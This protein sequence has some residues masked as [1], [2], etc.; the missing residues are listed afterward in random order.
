MEQRVRNARLVAVL[1]VLVA[2]VAYVPRLA[3]AKADHR[4]DADGYTEWTQTDALPDKAGKY[5]LAGNVKL[6]QTW[7]V[8]AGDTE[9]CLNGKTVTFAKGA[10][11]S[12]V[13]VPDGA[14]LTVTDCADKVGALKGGTGTDG[15]GGVVIVEEGGTFDLEDATVSGGKIAAVKESK[16]DPA[17]KEISQ[18]G[19]VYV[20]GTFAMKDSK[21][22][23]NKAAVGAGVYVSDKGSMS[24]E[25][26]AKVVDKNKDTAGKD[27]NVVLA[28]G[29]TI[30]VADKI[31]SK[32]AKK[33]NFGVTLLDAEGNE[34]A[35]VITSGYAEKMGEEDS[36]KY[37]SS[38]STVFKVVSNTVKTEARLAG[39]VTVA[40]N[41][42]AEDATG[43]MESISG[44]EGKATTLPPN[45]FVRDGYTFREWN[46]QADGNGDAYTDQSE[47][48]ELFDTTL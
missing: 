16:D 8:T 4:H 3:M 28:T 40:F 31:E 30:K 37:F 34:T 35:G 1:A 6:A 22:E 24:V 46:T 23:N 48:F 15:K 25:G 20:D 5:Y 38:N 41:K 26:T 29:K 14:R 17:S 2:V 19:G 42:N 9:L 13:D 39:V 10:K 45:T 32:D 27:S 7:K 44:E 47:G 21:I 11:G 36:S 12:L 43:E 33:A 18:G